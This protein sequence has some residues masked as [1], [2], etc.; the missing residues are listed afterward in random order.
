MWESIW[1]GGEVHVWPLDD[2]IG[3]EPGDCI[4]L[5]VTE[6][7]EREDGYIGWVVVHNSWDGRE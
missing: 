6:P 2:L 4:C 7:V 1:Q 3:H 5:P